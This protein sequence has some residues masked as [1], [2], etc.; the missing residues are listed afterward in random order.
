MDR[1]C[2]TIDI[3][4]GKRKLVEGTECDGCLRLGFLNG[5]VEVLGSD[6]FC[7]LKSVNVF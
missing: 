4:E 6:L 1:N 2:P 3:G 7:T 5:A